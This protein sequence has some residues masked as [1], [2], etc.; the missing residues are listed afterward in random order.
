MSKIPLGLHVSSPISLL[1]IHSFSSLSIP[2]VSDDGGRR[3]PATA[4][5]VGRSGR[6]DVRARARSGSVRARTEQPRRPSS[7][8]GLTAGEVRRWQLRVEERRRGWMATA[9]ARGMRRPPALSSWSW[10]LHPS[11]PVAARPRLPPS[12]LTCGIEREER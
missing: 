11:P 4:G 8:A 10:P 7:G 1:S 5:G 9:T 12:S 2:H 6:S 3:G